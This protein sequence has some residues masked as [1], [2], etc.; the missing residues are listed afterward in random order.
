VPGLTDASVTLE[1]PGKVL[2]LVA[3]T[4]AVA[5]GGS[6]C[7]RVIGATL[8]GVKVQGLAGFVDGAANVT[9]TDTVAAVGIVP[10]VAAGTHLAHITTNGAGS[11]DLRV[12]AVALG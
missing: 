12:V 4:A 11:N 8:D 2:V 10:D 3:G 9:T 6:P 1:Q 7:S 5:C